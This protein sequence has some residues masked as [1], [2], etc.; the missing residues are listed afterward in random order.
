M[1]ST[2][3]LLVLQP[4]KRVLTSDKQEKKKKK[5]ENEGN[6]NQTKEEQRVKLTLFLNPSMRGKKTTEVVVV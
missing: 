6:K 5:G 2:P 4:I 3:L 1:T